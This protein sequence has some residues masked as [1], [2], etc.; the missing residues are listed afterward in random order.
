MKR[1][2]RDFRESMPRPVRRI[3]LG[4]G[5]QRKRAAAFAAALLVAGLALFAA[6]RTLTK[7]DAGWTEIEAAPGEGSAGE[8]RLW[9]DLG[10][11]KESPLAERKLLSGVFSQA[12]RELHALYTPYEAV[13][14]VRNLWWINHHPNEDLEVDPRLY[15]ALRQSAAGRSVFMGPLYE[16]WDGV[17]FSQSDQEAREADPRLNE[18]AAAAVREVLSLLRDPREISLSFSENSTLRLNV[19]EKLLALAK[20]E[21]IG[22]YLDFGWALNAWMADGL[23]EALLERGWTRG[24]LASPD[25]F[26]RCLDG[27]GTF[28]LDVLAVRGTK[29]VREAAAEYGGPAALVQLLPAPLGERPRSYAYEDGTLRSA[30]ISLRDGLDHRPADGISA[31]SATKSCAELAAELQELLT[32]DGIDADSLDRLAVEGVSVL[33]AFGDRLDQA[34]EGFRLNA[35]DR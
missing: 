10:A 19:S 33:A 34:G 18:S 23:A 8:V 11:E 31:I 12:A 6:L 27:R 2:A 25:G 16:I 9:A 21:E 22:R 24:I 3:P 32:A 30:W 14:G 15:E 7:V 26:I 28:T 4:E 29:A 20:E 35:A 1:E 13:A 5:S 17:Y